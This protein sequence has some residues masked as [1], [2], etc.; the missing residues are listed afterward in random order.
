MLRKY[1]RHIKEH[2][3]EQ[4]KQHHIEEQIIEQTRIRIEK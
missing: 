1:K 3:I 4:S 2:I